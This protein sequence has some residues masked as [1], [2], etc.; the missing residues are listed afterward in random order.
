MPSQ[1]LWT[2]AEGDLYQV[3][4]V[5]PDADSVRIQT[6]W[7]SAAKRTHPDLGGSHAR[8]RAVHI[9]YLVLSDSDLRARYDR[10]R[11]PRVP[12]PRDDEVPRVFVPA[13]KR[14]HLVW[15]AIAAA[16]LAVVLSYAWPG[17]TIVAGIVCGLIV[18]IGYVRL[19][20]GRTDWR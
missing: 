17:F 14:T 13:A 8:F 11:T 16:V 10:S 7:R 9:A 3:L 5:P 18:T 12:P 6:A 4:G 1:E 19:A 20:H 15:L 2:Q